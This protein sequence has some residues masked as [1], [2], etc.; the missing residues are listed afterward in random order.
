MLTI[1]AHLI[2]IAAG[3][4]AP[5]APALASDAYGQLARDVARSAE[6]GGAR[7]VA[8]IPFTP[9]GRPD[10]EGGMILAERL[11]SSL[12]GEVSV[13]IVERTFLDRVLEEQKLGALGLVDPRQTREVGRLLGVDAIVTGTFIALANHHVEVHARVIDSS[14][15]RVLGA[16][17]VRVDKEWDDDPMPVNAL[18][19]VEAPDPRNF[20]APLVRLVPDP[21]RDAPNDG[22]VFFAPLPWAG[23][24]RAELAAAGLTFKT[25][26]FGY[27]VWTR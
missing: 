2:F 14:T 9:T 19:G 24:I 21:F 11:V 23:E 27:E 25:G 4:F 26:R 3:G 5:A 13:Q 20:P 10:K 7:R 16:A 18:W 6:H 17:T 12:A 1:A 22:A 15:A 8:V